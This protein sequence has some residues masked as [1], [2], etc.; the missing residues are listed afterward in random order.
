MK[1]LLGIIVLGLLLGGCDYF[2]K[3][4]I[5]KALADRADTVAIGKAW[6]KDCMTRKLSTL[7]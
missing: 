3:R 1:K 7:K 5:C 4:K 2:E 6:Q